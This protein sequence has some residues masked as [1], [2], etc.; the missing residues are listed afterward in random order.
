MVN[1][2][3]MDELQARA[4]LVRCDPHLHEIADQ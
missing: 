1:S 2:F 3:V 4:K